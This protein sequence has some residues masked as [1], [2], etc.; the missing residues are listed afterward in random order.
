[1]KP[2]QTSDLCKTADHINAI[3]REFR[4]EKNVN[5]LCGLNELVISIEH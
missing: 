5:L 4:L 1:M 3:I 2:C